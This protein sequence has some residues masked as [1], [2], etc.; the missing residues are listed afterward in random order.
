MLKQLIARGKFIC[1][2]PDFRE[3]A[4]RCGFSTHPD[5]LLQTSEAA[6]YLTAT[7]ANVGDCLR[8]NPTRANAALLDT[9]WRSST[10]C[11]EDTPSRSA[12]RQMIFAQFVRAVG[13]GD[14][15]HH[16]NGLMTTLIVEG[17]I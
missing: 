3:F 9:C 7:V 8:L 4:H 16:S 5:L 17:F 6:S 14:L 2:R 1:R 11:R 15:P 10:R 12:A 13:V